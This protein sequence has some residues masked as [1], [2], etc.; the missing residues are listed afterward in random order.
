VKEKLPDLH[1]FI[2]NV[3]R[4]S[5]NYYNLIQNIKQNQTL[6]VEKKDHKNKNINKIFYDEAEQLKKF[7]KVVRSIEKM[8]FREIEDE[9]FTEKKSEN[10]KNIL[11][12][13]TLV[14][15]FM[16]SEFK[17]IIKGMDCFDFIEF[18]VNDIVRS[19]F[20]KDYLVQKHYYTAYK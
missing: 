16:S 4:R 20:V 19:D 10:I 9:N 11:S 17:E 8:K 14:N 6:K 12:T 3:E 1:Q 5:I 2:S 7:D 18:G 15:H 13:V